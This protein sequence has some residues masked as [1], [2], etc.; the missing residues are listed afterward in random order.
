MPTTKDIE[1]D[2]Q[3]Y[4]RR[5][6]PEPRRIRRGLQARQQRR[7]QAKSRITIRI[8]T[9]ILAQFKQLVPDGQGYQRLMNQ[10]LREWL[11][12]QSIQELVHREL[13]AMAAQ[14][15]ALLQEVAR[16]P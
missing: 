9:D 11:S 16:R 6:P 1:F 2:Y 14:M 7:D 12:A 3:T 4:M 15:V 10:A 8:D 5:N 13:K